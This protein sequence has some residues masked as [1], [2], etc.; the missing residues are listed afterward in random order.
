MFYTSQVVSRI[1]SINRMVSCWSGAFGGL[2]SL[3][4]FPKHQTPQTSNPNS[5][6]LTA[7]APEK[8]G[9]PGNPEIPIG[10]HHF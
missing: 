9:P 3:D 5:L 1:S 10:K 8:W 2:E 4:S 7:S 6:E